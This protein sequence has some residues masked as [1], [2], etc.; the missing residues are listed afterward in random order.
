MKPNDVI[1]QT[2]EEN[3]VTKDSKIRVED[4]VSL[5]VTWSWKWEKGG[6]K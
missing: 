4:R 5:E 3:F 1:V 2:K 6:E